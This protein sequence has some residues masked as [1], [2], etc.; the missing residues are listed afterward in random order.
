MVS[1]EEIRQ[2]ARED[3]LLTCE[4][5]EDVYDVKYK[6]TERH[7]PRDKEILMDLINQH[8]WLMQI[9]PEKATGGECAMGLVKL[10]IRAS[11]ERELERV[12]NGD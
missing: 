8:D 4:S 10:N 12:I 7:T 9:P 5:G 3:F 2:E 6:V 1:L 11:I